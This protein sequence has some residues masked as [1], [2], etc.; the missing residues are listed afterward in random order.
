MMRSSEVEH[1]VLELADR[2]REGKPVEDSRVELKSVWPEPDH[3]TA[4]Q[5]AGLANAARGEP[6][7]VVIGLDPDARVG[8]TADNRELANW[9]PQI[10]KRFNGPAP[11][12]VCNLAV[13]CGEVVLIALL[14]ETTRAPF[15]TTVPTGSAYDRDVPW[16]EGTR[17]RSATREDLLRI[18]VP[19]GRAPHIELLDGNLI[20]REPNQRLGVSHVAVEMTIYVT[21][22]T[23]DPLFIPFHDIEGTVSWDEHKRAPF[24]ELNFHNPSTNV[25]VGGS[26]LSI[27]GPGAVEINATV[28]WAPAEAVAPVELALLL[29]TTDEH[30]L[31]ASTR[32]FQAYARQGDS[33]KIVGWFF[34]RSI[35]ASASPVT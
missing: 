27:A 8:K 32:T 22:R 7:L 12:L 23:R 1:W 13:T 28:G 24:L 20:L 17:T 26:E 4:R 6:V 30:R 18:L 19:A 31:V 3:R 35:R 16:R 25:A 21:P 10:Q 33:T 11:E 14:F 2:V 29:R 5:L 34:G 15:V 9:W